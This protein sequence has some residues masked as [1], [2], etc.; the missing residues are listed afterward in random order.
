MRP[1]SEPDHVALDRLGEAHPGV[2]PL[3][4]DVHEAFF[5]NDLDV[6]PRMPA[7]KSR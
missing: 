3:R 7:A 2:V 4:H 5:G 1:T 6:D